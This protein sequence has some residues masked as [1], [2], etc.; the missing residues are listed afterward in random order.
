MA[1]RRVANHFE[2]MK[3]AVIG[4]GYSG[5]SAVRRCREFG[6]E[7]VAFDLNDQV[8]G[9]WSYTSQVGVDEYGIPIQT[10]LYESLR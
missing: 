8:G 10:S 3:I 6:I 1:V 4:C 7:C 9:L 5:L 2:N